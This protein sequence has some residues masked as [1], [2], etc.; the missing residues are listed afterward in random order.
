MGDQVLILGAA[1]GIARAIAQRLAA[2]GHQLILAGRDTADLQRTA[3]DLGIR[4]GAT[5]RVLAFDAT[6]LAGHR[7]F[8]AR[9]L[10]AC[11]GEL[12]GIVF[13][14]GLLAPQADL[15]RDD[16]LA[17]RLIDV[18]FTS[19]ALL[20]AAAAA[21]M[22][23]RGRG[24]L[25]VLSSVAGDRGRPS[26]YLYGASKAALTAYLDGLRARL[27]HAGVDVVTVKP[28]PVDTPMTWGRPGMALLADPQR[29]AAD[30]CRAIRWH[31]GTI[32]TPWFW[33]PIMAVIRAMPET[34]FKRM[35]L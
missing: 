3:A 17:R 13:C 9:C 10:H 19:P 25:C 32:Y 23:P 7:A 20:L 31:R 27:Y 26:N 30:V 34:I 12:D 18:N 2:Q 16:G 4:F 35:K 29:V 15:D 1:S 8:F 21:Y 24:Y 11:G 6:D 22:Q 28:G 14:Y 5:P 33:R